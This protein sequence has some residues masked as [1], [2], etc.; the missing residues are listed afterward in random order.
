MDRDLSDEMPSLILL[1]RMPDPLKNDQKKTLV[2][3]RMRTAYA[4]KLAESLWEQH[5]QAEVAADYHMIRRF[6]GV[7][8]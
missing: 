8:D 2:M 5:P 4:R 3:D 1:A 6:A 7:E